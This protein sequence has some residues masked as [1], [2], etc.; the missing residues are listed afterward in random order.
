MKGNF[1]RDITLLTLA[2]QLKVLAGNS[3]ISLTHIFH[4]LNM[5]AD[6][7]SKIGLTQAPRSMILK[8]IWSSSIAEYTM[9]M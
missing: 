9:D 2:T 8:E 4:E 7:L 1:V 6:A 3:H 5:E